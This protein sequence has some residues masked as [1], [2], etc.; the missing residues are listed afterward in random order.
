MIT[1]YNTAVTDVASEI[2][3]TE[4]HMK[5]PWVT[6]D[7]LDLFDERRDLKKKR[8]EA[9]GAK[10]Y[11]EANRRVQK[12]VKKAKEEWIGAQCDEIETWL[13]KNN[14]KRAYQLVK[15]LTLEKQGRSSTILKKKRFSADGQNIAQNCTTMRVVETMLYWTAASPRKKICNQSSVRKLRLQ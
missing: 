3:Q 10:E 12:A 5:K 6:K 11:R 4:R 7:V 8:Y 1:T 15:D 14:S 2:L 13:N 9:E